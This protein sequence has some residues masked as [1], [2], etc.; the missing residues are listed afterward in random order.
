MFGNL[1]YGRFLETVFGADFKELVL[2]IAAKPDGYDPALEIL[3]MQ[4][5]SDNQEKRGYDPEVVETGRELLRRLALRGRRQQNDYKIGEV[6]KACLAGG[7]GVCIA[8]DI[9][10]KLKHSISKHETYASDKS[11]IVQ[12]L[13]EVQPLPSLDALFAG[14]DT[15]RRQGV[16]IIRDISMSHGNPL[17]AVRESDLFDWCDQ[18]PAVRYPTIA[19]VVS[20]FHRTDEKAPLQWTALASRVLEKAPDR[21]AVM[22]EFVKRFRPMSWSGSRAAIIEERAQLLEQ[23]VGYPDPLLV[24][25]IATEQIRLKQAIEREREYETDHDRT[26]DERFE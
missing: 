18:D 5:H 11:R 7:G 15:E 16:E 25:F 8:H 9:L 17:D 12:S 3:A 22:R 20:I 1:A 6:V 10:R 4:L 24:E 13:I 21:V 14:N 23:P 2:L 19:A 26:A